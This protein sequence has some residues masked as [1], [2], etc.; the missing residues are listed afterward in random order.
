M[1][2]F[3]KKLVLWQKILL[4]MG[5]GTI[6]GLI[7]SP[8]M[9]IVPAPAEGEAL[10]AEHMKPAGMVFIQMIKMLVVPLVFFSL[11]SG[12]TSMRDPKVMGRVGGKAFGIYMVTTMFSITIGLA[13][14][15]LFNPGEGVQIAYDASKTGAEHPGFVAMMLNI[16]PT[17]P[18][19]ALA[20]GNILQIIFFAILSGISLVMVGDKATPIIDTI[21]TL[22]E[23]MFK[24]THIVMA[25]AP[26]GVFA[27]MAWVTG[28]QG[29]DVLKSLVMLVITFL[30]GAALHVF[31]VYGGGVKLLMKLS[32]IRFFQNIGNA[33]AVAFSTSS[34]S[35]TLPVTMEV[36]EE[37]LGVS[38]S[39]ASFVLPLGATINMDGTALYQGVCVMFVA[40]AVG[41]DLAF[42]DWVTVVLTSTLASIGVAGIPGAGIVM[43][44]M[45]LGSVGLPVD[46]VAII[47]GVDRLLDMVRTAV[48]VTG[49][50][51]VCAYVDQSEGTLN[52]E[53]FYQ[54]NES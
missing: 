8:E 28:T 1:M 26:I 39:T 53:I 21:N 9:G 14:G 33:I 46:A 15:Y 49:D 5:L 16:I 4:G 34:S 41:V 35:A 38:N 36:A 31:I 12:V 30:T 18:V 17:N 47:L 6:C 11:I 48:N 27:L 7:I 51:F 2:A 20:E 22:N 23:M 52:E 40:Q 19:D 54:K 25:Y 24:M 50:S 13:V 10:W 44:G 43:L 29:V 45:V 37:N 3:W 32:P 42:A